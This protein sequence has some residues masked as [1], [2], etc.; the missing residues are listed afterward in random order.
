MRVQHTGV[1]D[2]CGPDGL[3]LMADGLHF[4]KRR[5][6]DELT[7]FGDKPVSKQVEAEPGREVG[8]RPV[9]PA[10]VGEPKPI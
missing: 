1:H 7:P 10:L 3:L 6:R 5:F 4:C 2:N 9:G 8:Q